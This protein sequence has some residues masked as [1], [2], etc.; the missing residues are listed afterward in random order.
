MHFELKYIYE[1]Y[2]HLCPTELAH[3]KEITISFEKKPVTAVDMWKE[4]LIQ[5][6]IIWCC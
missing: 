6:Y 5:F 2:L 4:Y 3:S 1:I